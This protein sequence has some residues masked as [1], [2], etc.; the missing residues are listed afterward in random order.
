[1]ELIKSLE[2]N[3]YLLLKNEILQLKKE[4]GILRA[5]T[6]FAIDNIR[7]MQGKENMTTTMQKIAEAKKLKVVPNDIKK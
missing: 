4:V 2:K 1:M 5:S 3:D 7:D 6:R